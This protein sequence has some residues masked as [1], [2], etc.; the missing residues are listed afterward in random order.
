MGGQFW[1]GWYW[2][3]AYAM[4]MIDVLGLDI[5]RDLELRA[6]ACADTVRSA[7]WWWPSQEFVIVSERPTAIDLN[8]DGS[9]RCARWE[10]TDANGPQSWEVTP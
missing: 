9:L 2:G 5:G 3:P 4:F 1:A 6:R 7:C 8:A 10:W